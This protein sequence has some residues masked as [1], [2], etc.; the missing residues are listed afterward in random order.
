MNLEVKAEQGFLDEG[1]KISF[2]EA[3]YGILFCPQRIFDDLY[4]EETF[5]LM[6]YGF[7]AVILSSLGKLE[8][9]SINPL[10]IFGIEIV[11][12]FSWFFIGLLIF[13]LSTIFKTPNNNLGRLLGFAGLST[14]P[15]LLLAPVSLIT[16]A[17]PLLSTGTFYLVLEVVINI[18][19]FILFWIALAKSFQLEAWRVL[20]IAIIPFILGIF[21]FT[22]LIAN[23]VGMFFQ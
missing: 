7:L 10:S 18:W 17:V 3:F 21:L 23:L 2:L 14:L 6:V 11:G 12:L 5:T 4:K 1:P 19:S 13:F 20:L 15:F 22:F 8:I 9:G 16:L